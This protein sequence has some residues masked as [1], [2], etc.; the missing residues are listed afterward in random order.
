MINVIIHQSKKNIKKL[1]S[2]MKYI[3]IYCVIIVTFPRLQDN[4]VSKEAKEMRTNG[5]LNKVILTSISKKDHDGLSQKLDLTN[6]GNDQVQQDLHRYKGKDPKQG[7]F[8]EKL[9]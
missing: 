9:M 5:F 2:K 8:L 4:Q 1:R 6:L 3:Y 7:E